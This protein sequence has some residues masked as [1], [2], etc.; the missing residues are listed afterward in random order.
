MIGFAE[1][2][3]K[4][5]KKEIGIKRDIKLIYSEYC[6]SPMTSGILSPTLILPICENKLKTAEYEYIL[7]HELI[8]IKHHDLLIK[9]IGLLVMA[10]HWYNPLVYIMFFETSVISEMYCDNIVI[11]GKSDDERKKYSNLILQFATQDEYTTK[12]KFF[13]GIANNKSKKVYKRRIL[14]MKIHK[15]YKTI[16]SCIIMVFLC[17]AGG[18]TTLAYNSPNVMSTPLEINLNGDEDNYFI[19][20]SANFVVLHMQNQL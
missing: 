12:N 2:T 4:K 15:K 1:K 5:I 14:E 3:Y 18:V 11:S 9:Y 10:V 16:L 6:Q 13:A 8:H 19:T 17:M 7:R 20:D